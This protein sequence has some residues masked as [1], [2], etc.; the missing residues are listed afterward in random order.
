MTANEQI[1]HDFYKAFAKGDT[2]AM[3]VCYAPDVKFMDPIFGLLRGKDVLLMWSMLIKKSKGNMKIEV[4][5]IKADD[6]LGSARWTA[7]Y[8]YSATNKK[9]INIVTANFQFK[10]GKIVKHTDDFDI[11]KWSSQALGLSGSL[12]GW[13]GFMQK[14]IQEGALLS[15]EKYKLG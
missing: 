2:A 12:L 1:I 7:T 6:F 4:A 3:F 15:L 13:T 5:D 8:N 11:W 10:N 9:V 14:K